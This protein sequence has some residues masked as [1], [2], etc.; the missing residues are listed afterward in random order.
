MEDS[1]DGRTWTRALERFCSRHRDVGA[2]AL[3]E[4]LDVPAREVIEHM[5]SL[6]VD[7]PPVALLGDVCPWCGG[8]MPVS[9]G[10]SR[11]GL[12]DACHV[13]LMV[14]LRESAGAEA[15]AERLSVRDGAADTRARSRRGGVRRG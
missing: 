7:V 11:S 4:L 3:A 1:D 12:C 6:G 13:R 14:S 15:D 5:L 8:R 9:G 2:G 10:G